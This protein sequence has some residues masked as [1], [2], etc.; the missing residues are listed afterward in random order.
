[1][2]GGMGGDIGGGMGGGAS[3]LSVQEQMLATQRE[4]ERIQGLMEGMG[5]MGGAGQQS[6]GGGMDGGMG[7]GFGGSSSGGGLA[8]PVDLNDPFSGL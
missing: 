2:G 5:S 8:S 1:M 7:G 4:I 3:G 6:I